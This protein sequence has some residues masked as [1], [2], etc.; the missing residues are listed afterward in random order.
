[1]ARTR[2]PLAVL[3]VTAL[4]V[5]S[6]SRRTFATLA[7]STTLAL[8]AGCLNEDG[9]S[10]STT[11]NG[12]GT[13]TESDTSDDHAAT[14]S[15]GTEPS[16][17]DSDQL[18]SLSNDSDVLE[19]ATIQTESEREV[20]EYREGTYSVQVVNAVSDGVEVTMTVEHD[21]ERV[22]DGL[23]QIPG[24]GAVVLEFGASGTYDLVV[25]TETATAETTVD[26]RLADCSVGVT[27]MAVGSGGASEL[28]GEDGEDGVDGFGVSERAAESVD[29]DGADGADGANGIETRTALQC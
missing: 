12:T 5:T 8:L 14:D 19:Q 3:T 15:T 29:A 6:V 1:M 2:A 28:G 13:A 9:T 22:V 10:G 11:P 16:Q 25:A 17:I 18:E 23:I 20:W 4:L 26:W 24:A 21:G 7:G 27:E